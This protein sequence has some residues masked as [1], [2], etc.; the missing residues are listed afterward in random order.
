MSVTSSTTA[1]GDWEVPSHD[2]FFKDRL[3]MVSIT[4]RDGTLMD[5]SSISEEDI[6]EVCV[7]QGCTH[8]LGVLFYS[9][10]ES[11]VFFLT[12]DNLKCASCDI[13][14]ETELHDEAI[15]VRAMAP[16]EAHISAY[17]MVWHVKPSKGSGR[18]HTPPQLT[19]PG[20]ETLHHLHTELGDLNN[21]VLHQLMADLNQELVQCELIVLSSD[22]LQMTG[23]THQAVK[24]PRRMTRKSPFQEGFPLDHPR[25][26]HVLHHRTR[27]GAINYYPNIRSVHRHP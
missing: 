26:H 11:V 21:H 19:P 20:G 15:T 5:A 3:C 18:L 14:G 27:H 24:S 17:A 7:K 23:Y 10:A 8:P 1:S 22:P 12:V 9:P 13:T 25:D 4:R 16:T 2:S 6:I